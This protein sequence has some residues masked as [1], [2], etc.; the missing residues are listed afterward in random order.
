MN[1]RRLTLWQLAF[2]T[3]PSVKTGFSCNSQTLKK[4]A[5]KSGLSFQVSSPDTAI[6]CFRRLFIAAR[7][8]E[9]RRVKCGPTGL[10]RG[11]SQRCT[12]V[13]R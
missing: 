4:D 9:G 7:G 12:I 6:C 5:R 11:L 10:M 1:Y 3:C 2:I 13:A 8:V